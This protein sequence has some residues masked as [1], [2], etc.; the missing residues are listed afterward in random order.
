M[1]RR[2]PPIVENRFIGG[3]PV[4]RQTVITAIIVTLLAQADV[5][6]V[7]DIN[8]GNITVQLPAWPR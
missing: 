4:P 6:I 8:K 2:A 7:V 3:H 1:R 5:I